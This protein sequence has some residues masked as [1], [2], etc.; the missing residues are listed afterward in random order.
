M[1]CYRSLVCIH[2]DEPAYQLAAAATPVAVV[3]ASQFVPVCHSTVLAGAEI[4]WSCWPRVVTKTWIMK[5][6]PGT[7]SWPAGVKQ[8]YLEPLDHEGER[9]VDGAGIPSMAWKGSFLKDISSEKMKGHKSVSGSRGS[10]GVTLYHQYREGDLP[11]VQITLFSLI[12][13]LQVLAQL[14]EFTARL[15]F[16]SVLSSVRQQLVESQGRDDEF[17]SGL[18]RSMTGILMRSKDC[19]PSCMAAVME[20]LWEHHCGLEIG[21]RFVFQVAK[22]SCL[23]PLGILVMESVLGLSSGGGFL[24]FLLVWSESCSCFVFLCS[25]SCAKR[26]RLEAGPSTSKDDW[27]RVAS[28]YDDVGDVDS[29]RAVI[30]SLTGCT[31]YT[32]KAVECEER[33]DWTAAAEFYG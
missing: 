16:S 1:C 5:M 7:L 14:D 13:P 20:Y 21:C 26:T 3:L 23:H 28:L 18:L 17:S 11:D 33:M 9:S 30:A 32:Q 25:S 31:E 8:W 19:R 6:L 2:I 10:V 27:F 4:F 12:A 15:L 24:T 29:M 22:T